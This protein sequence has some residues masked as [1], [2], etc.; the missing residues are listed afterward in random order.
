M[1]TCKSMTQN[2]LASRG[3]WLILAAVLAVAACEG[4]E[5]EPPPPSQ[6]GSARDWSFRDNFGT[7]A[8]D[9]SPLI[10]FSTSR[11]REANEGVGGGIGVNAFLWEATL[12]TINF[13]PLASADPFGGLIITDWF[14][15]AT[16]PGERVK[17]HVQIRDAAL[18]ADS[19]TVSVFRQHRDT[20]GDWLD[21]PADAS[22]AR[23]I[24]DHI[25]T[26]ARELRV[27]STAAG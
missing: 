15:P 1:E 9:G 4:V 22:T 3:R 23:E 25:L 19:V 13:M 14:Q 20:T 11:S 18:R 24:E 26:R 27:A 21:A 6:P 12:D 2:P 16:T 7:I 10:T 17:L 8:G 5:S